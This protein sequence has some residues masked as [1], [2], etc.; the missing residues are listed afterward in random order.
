MT[1][2]GYQQVL[3]ADVAMNGFHYGLIMLY[4]YSLQ[5]HYHSHSHH[6]CLS[7]SL[8]GKVLA[9]NRLLLNLD[10]SGNACAVGLASR[11]LNADVGQDSVGVEGVSGAGEEGIAAA[12]GQVLVLV[13]GPALALSVTRKTLSTGGV[14]EDAL[15]HAR[16]IDEELLGRVA[17]GVERQGAFL[18]V[19]LESCV[20][21]GDTAVA[22]SLL[23]ARGQLCEDCLV[24]STP[25]GVLDSA[26]AV[27]GA[28]AEEGDVR[29]GGS[30]DTGGQ[31]S[32]G[33]DGREL[34]FDDGFVG[35]DG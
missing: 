17:G 15:A 33:L 11:V 12:E 6:S 24:H 20:V 13:D 19:Q 27:D 23:L 35:G 28:D 5:I 3:E 30:H 9:S 10:A 25:G 26:A 18:L 21:A 4:M 29:V 32:D 8:V 1:L 31:E 16:A 34:H 14:E 7:N 2:S 22:G